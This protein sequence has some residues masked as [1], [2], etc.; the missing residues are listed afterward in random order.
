MLVCSHFRGACVLFSILGVCYITHHLFAVRS[1]EAETKV[2]AV[3]HSFLRMNTLQPTSSVHDLRGRGLESLIKGEIREPVNKTLLLYCTIHHTVVEDNTDSVPPISKQY[4]VPSIVALCTWKDGKIFQNENQIFVLWI[5]RPRTNGLC[6][7]I[8]PGEGH[9]M[10]VHADSL[11]VPAIM[12]II[13]ETE[14]SRTRTGETCVL[15]L[16]RKTNG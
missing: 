15:D 12:P 13:H 9:T 11:E 14:T 4:S 8:Q 1:V 6:S 16:A 7:W 2:G 5:D 10:S 3:A